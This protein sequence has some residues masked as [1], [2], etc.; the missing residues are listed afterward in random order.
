M[1]VAEKQYVK[2]IF[3]CLKYKYKRQQMLVNTFIRIQLFINRIRNWSHH[4]F[5]SSNREQPETKER[6]T[7]R[8]PY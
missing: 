6:I 5:A 3:V 7:F 4:T 2:S 1:Q 8:N